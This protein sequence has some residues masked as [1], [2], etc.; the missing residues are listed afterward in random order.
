MRIAVV[1][2]LL[3]ACGRFGFDQSAPDAALP[4]VVPPPAQYVSG[5]R[6]RAEVHD[7]AGTKMFATWYDTQLGEECER[8]VAEDGVMRCI[9]TRVTVGAQYSDATC[10]T[11]LLASTQPSDLIDCPSAGVLASQQ[12]GERYRVVQ[13]GAKYFGTIYQGTGGPCSMLGTSTD[14]DYYAVGP[15]VPA[16]MFVAFHEERTPSGA[17]EYIEYV[18]D[19][20]AR[21]LEQRELFVTAKAVRCQL[22]MLAWN[23]VACVAK[24]AHGFLA[25][26][27]AACTERAFVTAQPSQPLGLTYSVTTCEEDVHQV[28]V[29]DA[30]TT[31]YDRSNDTAPCTEQNLGGSDLHA[32]RATPIAASPIIDRATLVPRSEPAAANVVGSDWVF[33]A[34]QALPAGY[35][36]KA[37]DDQCVVTN[38]LTDRVCAPIWT[39]YQPVYTDATCTIEHAGQPKCRGNWRSVWFPAGTLGIEWRC[40]GLASR[41]R[42]YDQPIA[43]PYYERSGAACTLG[44]PTV[45]AP[46]GMSMTELPPS[47]MST[48]TRHMD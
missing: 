1:F 5:T 44:D 33:T 46:L 27:D 48:V 43:P 39:G 22:E 3:T 12:V 10:T 18:G 24:S 23:Q 28:E 16:D 41:I 40:E 4:T 42:L 26:A 38:T 34:G 47:E 17:F 9:P 30:L 8:H 2:A 36:D 11:H 45:V 21:E 32:F 7:I 6:L 15:T 35:Y 19:D 20:G 13:V 31:Y 14:V 37:H 25:Y 29:G